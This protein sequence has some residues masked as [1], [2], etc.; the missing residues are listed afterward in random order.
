MA[1]EDTWHLKKR[2][3]DGKLV[4]SKRYG[5][6]L[7][8]RVRWPGV[9]TRSYRTLG[10]AERSWLKVRTEK[11]EPEVTDATVGELVDRWLLTKR[12]LSQ[13]GYEACRDAGRAVRTAWGERPAA[14]LTHEDLQAWV[15]ALT[16]SVKVRQP[17]GQV[18]QFVRSASASQRHKVVQCLAGAFHLVDLHAADGLKVPPQLPRDARFLSMAELRRLAVAA[19]DNGDMVLLLGTTG[20][21]IGEACGLNVGDVDASRGRIRV[22]KS[23]GGRSRDVPVPASIL[24]RLDLGRTSDAPL[25][26]SAK[27]RRVT[28][29]NWRARVF[30][31]AVMAAG[32]G[33]MRI[34]DLRHTAASLAIASGADV[35]TVQ[36]MLGHK[37]AKMTL[38][39]YGHRWDQHLDD[40]GRRM[41]RLLTDG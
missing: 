14:K 22:R 40:V 39:L 8:Y 25:L 38:D 24:A 20:M 4:R 3:A 7:R 11:P 17:D 18:V 10:E 30:T 41:D 28:Q 31:P 21:R 37:S 16:V 5:R 33:A 29:R 6:G 9:P 26:I 12:G 13:K 34:H 2:D 35:K 32:I 36:E 19:G 1:V 15:A 23:K 27:G